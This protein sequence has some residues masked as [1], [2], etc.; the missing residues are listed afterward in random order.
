M[1]QKYEVKICK[2]KDYSMKVPAKKHI[3]D[4][5]SN[6]FKYKV[7]SIYIRKLQKYLTSKHVA[8]YKVES[9]SLNSNKNIRKNIHVEKGWFE[10]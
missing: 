7:V 9:S 3:K 4:K 2:I 1:T 8:E 10:S 6:T 5:R